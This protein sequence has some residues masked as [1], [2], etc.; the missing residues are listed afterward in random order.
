[1]VSLRNEDEISAILNELGD[2]WQRGDGTQFAA[3]FAEDA[4]FINILGM[5]AKGRSEIAAWHDQLFKGIYAES[6]AVFSLKAAR[7]LTDDVTHMVVDTVLDVPA[8]PRAGRIETVAD[9]VLVRK[10]GRWEIAA[11]HNTRVVRP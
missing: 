1:M 9:G 3:A 8:G 4:D 10:G 2:A 5:H 11:F 7:R 6:A